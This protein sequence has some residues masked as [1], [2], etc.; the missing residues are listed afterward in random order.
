MRI[1]PLV[2]S[3]AAQVGAP[4]ATADSRH[5]GEVLFSHVPPIVSSLVVVSLELAFVAVICGVVYAVS[6]AILVRSALGRGSL[7]VWSATA[8][9]KTRKALIVVAILLTA[10][11]LAFNGWLFARRLDVMPYTAALVRSIDSSTWLALMA[12]LGKLAL[13]IV[14]LVVA[15]RAVRWA[16]ESAERAINRWDRIQSNNE[17]LAEFFK[18]LEHVIVN[19][20]RMMLA[21]IACGWFAVPSSIT[22]V[23]MTVIRIYLVIAVGLMIVR[24]VAAIVDTLDGFSQRSAQNRG[25]SHYYERVRPLLPTL[26]TCLEYTLWIA[27]ASLV[28][29]QIEWTRWLADWG[30]RL[31]QAIGIFFAGRVVIE[32]GSLEIGRRML[33][34]E[35]LEETDRR[36]RATMIPL[37]RSA[38]TYGVYFGTLVLILSSLG[39]NP[40][41]FLAGAGILGLVIGFGAQSMINDVVSGFF[42]LFEN[43]YLVGDMVQVADA[44]GVVEAIEFRTTK[45]RDADGRLHIIRNGDTKPL[46]N[47][48]RDYSMAVVS[49]EMA[50]DTDL[51]AVFGALRHAGE[52][53]RAENPDVVGDT[54]INGV[55]AFGPATMTVRTSIRV[56][57]GRHEAVAAEL[58]FLIM[59]TFDRQMLGGPRKPLAPQTV[60]DRMPEPAAAG[61]KG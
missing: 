17:S 14:G 45:I 12:A 46:I 29:L 42:I 5:A 20:A 38:F 35:G 41:P 60:V 56:K 49:V 4:P 44:K 1:Q 48:S 37:V 58:R 52:R 57:P 40:M 3:V 19:L 51:R 31:V 9:V 10:G 18:G 53:L 32:L 50:Y 39:F 54:E 13:G 16:L 61:Q 7:A 2:A 33:P 27:V 21:V 36:R 25:W 34:S 47:Y 15:T 8:I 43:I 55:T 6:K 11:V 30:P 23:L 28:L 24:C 59:E 26:R 22:S